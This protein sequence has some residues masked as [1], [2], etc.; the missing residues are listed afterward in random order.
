[1]FSTYDEI[2]ST[3]DEYSLP[4]MNILYLWWIFSTCDKMFSTYDEKF[5]I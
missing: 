1:M 5:T 3:C 2:F 4:V